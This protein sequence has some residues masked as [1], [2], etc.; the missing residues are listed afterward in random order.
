LGNGFNLTSLEH[1]VEFDLNAPG[2]A[3]ATSWT[4]AN[5][6]DAF[7]V[8]DRN[9]NGL[10][11]SGLELFGNVT[12]QPQP[13]PG[14]A[15]NGFLALAQYDNP[16]NGGNGDGV[17]DERDTVYAALQLWRDLN[18]NGASEPAELDR[19]TDFQV[20]AISL[21]FKDSRHRDRW[22]NSFRYRAHVNGRGIGRWAY[23]VIFVTSPRL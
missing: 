10:I 3:S 11:D 6:D 18:H 17:I 15:R 14:I 8:L 9:G 4:A 5:S 22:G 20:D 7:L 2:A 19:L 16:V 21:A 13:A 1:G 12:L 23:D